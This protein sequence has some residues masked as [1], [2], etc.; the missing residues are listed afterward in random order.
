MFTNKM[1]VIL[2][3]VCTLLLAVGMVLRSTQV[4]SAQPSLQE[5]VTVPYPG[6]LTDEMDQWVA[7]GAYDF[8]FA[9]YNNQTGGEAIWTELHTGVVVEGGTF[10][11]L[12]G[13]VTPISPETL[14]DG[15]RWLEVAVRG[16]QE[17]EFSTLTP[18][19]E[20]S[21]YS[22][23]PSIVNSSSLACAHDH[24]FESWEGADPLYAFKVRNS[25]TGDGVVGVASAGG[26]SG[27][28]GNNTGNG[29]GVFGRSVGG[30]GISGISS[31]SDGVEGVASA[32]NKSGLY[33]YNSGSGYGIFGRST[34]GFGMGIDGAGDSN[35]YDTIGDLALAGTRGEIFAF[36]SY[37]N[38]YSNWNI[39][40]SLDDD[41]ND[42]NA[43]FRIWNGADV[44]T[45]QFCEDGSKSAVIQT[46]DHGQRAVYAIESSEVWLEDIGSASLINGE[47]TLQVEP[48]FAQIVNMSDYHIFMTPICQE[49]MVMFVSSKTE[50]EFTVQGVTL[51]GRPSDCAFDYR[52][53]AKRLGLEDYRLEPV[54]TLGTEAQR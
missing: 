24:L 7:D 17:T 1:L 51:D 29:Y 15:S 28:Y 47:A 33:G 20:L 16:P 19:Q 30:P 48:I 9:I 26:K 49:P 22:Q 23:L 18:R 37:L 42:S 50:K 27:V 8:S 3:V 14:G 12:L 32:S 44:T 13:N 21:K 40:F 4:V 31:N 11:T 52:I 36:G 45:H 25:G 53:T 43:C 5:G 10:N 35:G 34:G 6:K 41:N 46:N 2:L 54:M 38:L 39:N